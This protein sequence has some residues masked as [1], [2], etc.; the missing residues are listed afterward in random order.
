MSLPQIWDKSSKLEL[1]QN[2]NPGP[3][4]EK[5]KEQLNER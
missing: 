1:R 4:I 5:K 3:T 2:K